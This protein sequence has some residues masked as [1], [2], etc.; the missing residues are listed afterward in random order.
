MVSA[1]LHLIFLYIRS[2]FVTVVALLFVVPLHLPP[3]CCPSSLT[4]VS[5]SFAV[6]FS[7]LPE[8]LVSSRD[9]PI[10]GI[11]HFADYRYQPISMLVSVNCHLHSW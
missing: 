5:C 11:G 7:L 10:I 6:L 3:F 8:A 1:C 4:A 9:A 2:Q